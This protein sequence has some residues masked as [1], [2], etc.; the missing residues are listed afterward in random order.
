MVVS[1]YSLRKWYHGPIT[2]FT[3]RDES[4]DM[5]DVFAAEPA[6]D[7]DHKHYREVVCGATSSY[8]TKVALLH[9]GPYEATLLLDADTLIT[10]DIS[11]II[12]VVTR[13]PLTV[14][15]TGRTTIHTPWFLRLLRKEWKALA[16]QLN[17]ETDLELQDLLYVAERLP[18]PGINGGVV[19][20]Q[21]R[22]P[23]V[24]LWLRLTDIARNLTIPDEMA[25]QILL[26]RCT[27]A[28]VDHRFN[29]W[30]LSF[31][32]VD[33]V[34]IWHFVGCSHLREGKSAELWRPAYVECLEH[35]I[36]KITQWSRVIWT[37]QEM[38]KIGER[39]WS[40][41]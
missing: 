32:D 8:V 15:A 26:P 29:C 1:I 31:P 4:H 5:G 13:S 38:Y 10:G 36:A 41:V 33:D 12:D 24:D 39:T 40:A 25:L 18:Q 6:L 21:G 3:T 19:G 37:P 30:P 28:V 34:R 7:V 20:V 17:G 9:G 14:T 11:Q 23:D 2:V 16:A 22:S 27:K 35:D